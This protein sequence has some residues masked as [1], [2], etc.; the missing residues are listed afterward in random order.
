VL[1]KHFGI[2][3]EERKKM[4]RLV[5]LLQAEMKDHNIEKHPDDPNK[6]RLKEIKNEPV[7][8]TVSRPSF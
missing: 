8:S 6:Y 3:V 5:K 1:Y 4:S 7:I 2:Q